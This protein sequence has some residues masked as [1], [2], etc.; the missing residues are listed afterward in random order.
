MGSTPRPVTTKDLN[1]LYSLR[2]LAKCSALGCRMATLAD[3][4][5]N[6]A[7]IRIYAITEHVKEPGDTRQCHTVSSPL[8]G[9]ARNDYKDTVKPQSNSIRQLSTLT[10]PSEDG[11]PD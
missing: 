9:A 10:H 11:P 2:S 1:H 7:R 8:L 4:R 3:E 5:I 6:R